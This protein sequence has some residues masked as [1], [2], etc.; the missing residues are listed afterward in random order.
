MRE[1][2]PFVLVGLPLAFQIATGFPSVDA[3]DLPF[4]PG[5]GKVAVSVVTDTTLQFFPGGPHVPR[6]ATSIHSLDGTRLLLITPD[7]VNQADSSE[8]V[9]AVEPAAFSP[10]GKRIAITAWHGGYRT[11]I[12]DEGKSRPICV[13]CSLSK[14]GKRFDRERQQICWSPGG[15]RL[16][17]CNSYEGDETISV[18]EGDSLRLLVGRSGGGSLSRGLEM[19]WLKDRTAFLAIQHSG[20]NSQLIKIPVG[21]AESGSAGPRSR[22]RGG[23]WEIL[24]SSGGRI[25]GIAWNPARDTL[26]FTVGPKLYLFYDEGAHQTF[27][28]PS[29]YQS[30]SW[31]TDGK[32]LSLYDGSRGEI[33]IVQRDGQNPWNATEEMRDKGPIPNVVW[34]DAQKFAF[35]VV[36]PRHDGARLF[37]GDAVAKTVTE[38]VSKNLVSTKLQTIED[39]VLLFKIRSRGH[40]SQVPKRLDT[41]AHR[42]R[43]VKIDLCYWSPRNSITRLTTGAFETEETEGEYAVSYDPV[44]WVKQKEL[45]ARE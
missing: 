34:L 6:V 25:S 26:A 18:F 28:A 11:F 13:T 33:L 5:E 21:G 41:P 1:I 20:G 14:K 4:S 17:V 7:Q 42:S 38:V 23:T 37:C 35:I 45:D 12:L 19:T 30:I 24:S 44:F 15:D 16:A 36:R 9:T 31:S 27:T 32:R 29:H 39:G 43:K 40:W 8:I 2:K 3:R 22:S 10:D